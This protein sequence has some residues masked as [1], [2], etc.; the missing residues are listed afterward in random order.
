MATSG[1]GM[2]RVSLN[3]LDCNL[4]LILDDNLK[5]AHTLSEAGCAYCWAGARANL[6]IFRGE[7]QHRVARTEIA[8]TGGSTAGDK[9]LVQRVKG[10]GTGNDPGLKG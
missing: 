2:Y 4:N 6:G 8:E 3:P 10:E 1:Q 9:L 5:Q 7:A